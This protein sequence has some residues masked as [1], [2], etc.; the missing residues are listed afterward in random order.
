MAGNIENEL[1][2]LKE[3]IKL[4][5][6]MVYLKNNVSS[7][8][9]YITKYMETQSKLS[10]MMKNYSMDSYNHE[11]KLVELLKQKAEIE[12][13]RA[14]SAKERVN[15]EKESIKL[16]QETIR[17]KEKVQEHNE[18]IK[19][20]N[21]EIVEQTKEM[22]EQTEE[23]T[24][25]EKERLE[26]KQKQDAQERLSYAFKSKSER[27]KEDLNK[28]QN[29]FAKTHPDLKGDKL[30]EE[31]KKAGLVENK[32]N[33]LIKDSL[34][35][36]KV[37]SKNVGELFSEGGKDISVGAGL[38]SAGVQ[39]FNK[40]VQVFSNAVHE[41]FKKQTGSYENNFTNIATMSGMSKETYRNNQM[42]LGGF[43]KNILNEQGLMNNIRTSDVQD[44]WNS[45]ATTGMN[46]SD[47]LA[48]ALD[49][50]ITRTIVPYLDTTSESFNI[51]NS[52]ING[53]FV[54]Q[55]RGIN[56]AN[57]EIAGNNYATK[58]VLDQLMKAVEPMS[59]E[60][61]QNLAQ[62]SEEVTSYINQL[63]DAGYTKDAAT[64]KATNLFKMQKYGAN[65]I[66]SMGIAD[67]LTYFKY[68][69]DGTNIYDPNQ[70]ADAING[71]V[72]TDQWIAGLTLGYG[73]TTKGMITNTIGGSFGMDYA[74]MNG[75]LNLNKK[76]IKGSSLLANSKKADA[77]RYADEATKDLA[78]DKLQTT[79][80]LT[81]IL[82]ENLTNEVSAFAE[83]L[84]PWFDVLTTAVS[85]I[86]TV[87]G[88]KLLGKVGGKVL[89]KIGGSV[90]KHAAEGAASGGLNLGFNG[91]GAA[92]GVAGAATAVAGV[93]GTAYGAYKT[94]EYGSQFAKSG[95]GADLGATIT[96][97]AGTA[98]IAGGAITALTASGPIGWA[99]M[100]VG[101][102]G[103]VAADLIEDL[104][105]DGDIMEE[106]NEASEQRL[107]DF[108][109][110]HYK[111][112]KQ[113]K[114]LRDDISTMDNTTTIQQQ[115]IEEGIISQEELKKK[116][117]ELRDS[118]GNLKT[119][120][121]LNKEALIALTDQY[122]ATKASLD[123][124]GEALL[125]EIENSQNEKQNDI[126]KD[127]WELTKKKASDMND[128][129][130]AA[131]GDFMEDYYYWMKNLADNGDKDAAHRIKE[132]E[133]YGNNLTDHIVSQ[134]DLNA[135]NSLNTTHYGNN[136]D[137][138]NL[139][140]KFMADGTNIGNITR[141]TN[142]Q[143]YLGLDKSFNREDF[144]Q[145]INFVEQAILTKNEESTKSLLNQAKSLGL[146]WDELGKYEKGREYQERLKEK[147]ISSYRVGTDSIPFDNYPALLHEGEAVLTA[148]TANELRGLIDEYRAT[149]ED[150][151]KLEKA[152]QDQ[153]EALVTRLDAIYN[154]IGNPDSDTSIMP[155]KFRQRKS[156]GC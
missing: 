77:G 91:M 103:L 113:L 84:G 106:L 89:G 45:L 141:S 17:N 75:A 118:S 136:D 65:D 90:G 43:G 87:L 61:I 13:K 20:Q 32:S 138:Y 131:V 38:I 115:M 49:N 6:R 67:Q 140:K 139:Y 11:K 46:Q 125:R 53:D 66:S 96:A 94:Y 78:N 123:N 142:I 71:A 19:K 54:K 59:D 101:A 149:K 128:E 30:V 18:E 83:M 52:R 16:E 88:A 10:S 1:S 9:E 148:S 36:L 60:A 76:G 97:G 33:E 150:N 47:I 14:K 70:F 120:Q 107:E 152:I 55:I 130:K 122:T 22:V 82:A 51:L 108:R 74:S 37:G 5:E 34:K 111:E 44:M 21:K 24:E 151:I 7:S 129:E 23:L 137:T 132:W 8:E 135:I 79:K 35:S 81:D 98:A 31:L 126:S 155:R 50:V 104:G 144:S 15:A 4:L 95:K 102:I 58:D 42:A 56:K 110:Q 57:L 48:T 85:G 133:K 99:I 62:G 40:A 114:Q 153:T 117:D 86:A 154:K 80:Q 28:R 63:I 3:Q 112:R 93:A 109:K 73:D 116:Q 41:G 156:N 72:E 25:K 39:T 143:S 100:A 26:Q 92:T 127:I 105:H 146:T 27:A 147:G 134:D 29:E 121:E 2:Q 145:A 124:T 12:E 64:Q 68:L 69:Q 119:E